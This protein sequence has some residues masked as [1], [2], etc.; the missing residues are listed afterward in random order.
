MKK[1]SMDQQYQKG[2]QFQVAWGA[3]TKCHGKAK[4]YYCYISMHNSRN[5][6]RSAHATCHNRAKFAVR[7]LFKAPFP[8][9]CNTLIFRF[10]Q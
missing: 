8:H 2:C 7:D 4:S 3:L 1:F 10:Q 6:A 9:L 5:L